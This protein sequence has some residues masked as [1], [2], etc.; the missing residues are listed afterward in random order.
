MEQTSLWQEGLI[1]NSPPLDANGTKQIQTI[2]GTFLYYSRALECPTLLALNNISTQQSA[3]TKLIIDDVNWMVDFFHTYPNAKLR[4]FA[5][6][7]QLRVN[8]NT[9]YLAMP[10]A[11]NRIVGYFISHLIQS[12]QLQQNTPQCA[13]PGRISGYQECCL[14]S[15]RG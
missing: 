15:G 10:G 11:T 12:S 3:P 8:P 1:C 7:M 14:L 6:D 9:A 5:G 4:F 2:V 13:H